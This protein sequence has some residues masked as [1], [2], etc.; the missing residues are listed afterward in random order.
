[1]SFMGSKVN[2]TKKK[3]GKLTGYPPE[4]PEFAHGGHAKL[5]HPSQK[6]IAGAIKKPNK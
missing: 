3:S 2:S 1:M 5:G 4:I 6:H